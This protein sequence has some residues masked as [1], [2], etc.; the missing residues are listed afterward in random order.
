MHNDSKKV[1]LP[2][3][4][5]KKINKKVV[6]TFKAKDVMCENLLDTSCYSGEWYTL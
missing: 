4:K 6:C 3:P 1:L 2:P 5:K